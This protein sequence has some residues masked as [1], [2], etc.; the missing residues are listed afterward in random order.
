MT[1]I[2]QAAVD[3]AMQAAHDIGCSCRR[4]PNHF[5][6]LDKPEHFRAVLEAAEEAW[7]HQPLKRDLTGTTNGQFDRGP[8]A[9][10][11]RRHGRP[12]QPKVPFGFGP[13]EVRA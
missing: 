13:P 6:R 12:Q 10:P 2:P 3:A 7:P 11:Y 4:E 5:V 9:S 8:V 1:P